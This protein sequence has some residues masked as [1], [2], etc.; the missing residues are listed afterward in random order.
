M[1]TIFAI[2]ILTAACF[3]Q[4][5]ADVNQVGAFP[6]SPIVTHLLYDGSGNITFVCKSPQA[7]PITTQKVSNSTL[8]NIVVSANVGT[9]TT[10]AAHGLY[11]GARV[12]ITGATVDTDLNGTYTVRSVTSSTAYTIT[13][14]AVA[15]ATYTDAGLVITTKFPLLTATRWAILAMPLNSSSLL[16]GT[17]F[18]STGTG[19]GLACSTASTNQ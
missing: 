12:T 8:T 3:A 15:D 11:V 18:E 1:K 6:N 4:G 5:G 13:T 17:V 14:A 9:V 2:F 7:G 16:D 10:S 19:Y